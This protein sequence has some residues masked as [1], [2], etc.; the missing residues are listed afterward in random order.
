MAFK[1]SVSPL[2]ILGL[3]QVQAII[4]ASG[5]AVTVIVNLADSSLVQEPCAALQ[6]AVY[7]VV[8]TGFTVIELPVSP[9]DQI[10]LPSQ[11][12]EE[13]VAASPIQMVV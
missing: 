12:V 5:C 1:V 13:S 2:H 11:P 10:T 4:G 6:T 7:S 8:V 3:A 9:L